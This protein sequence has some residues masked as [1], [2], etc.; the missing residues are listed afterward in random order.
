MCVVL[1]S[2][3][4]QLSSKEVLIQSVSKLTCHHVNILSIANVMP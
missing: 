4:F 1:F 2:K 3:Q